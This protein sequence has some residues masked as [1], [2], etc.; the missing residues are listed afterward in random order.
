MKIYK[1][2]GNFLIISGI[3]G[4]IYTFY[5]LINAYTGFADKAI[6]SSEKGVYIQIPKINAYARI[7]TDVDPDNEGIYNEALKKGVAHARGT[8]LPGGRGTSFLFAHSSSPPWENTRY[9][10][11]FLRL[12]ELEKG[13]IV[14]IINNGKAMVFRVYD[15][16]EVWPDEVSY[17]NEANRDKL[18]LQ[19][20]TP[21]GTSIRRLLV[22]AERI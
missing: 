21:I 19:T 5:P 8:S 22:F 17:L 15:K 12:N 20:C 16:K 18:I 4:I 6:S 7:V 2:L 11:V 3:L 9:N 13:D 14:E 10:S 1:F